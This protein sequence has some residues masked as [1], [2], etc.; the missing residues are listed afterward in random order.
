M[1][2]LRSVSR[3]FKVTV[4][5]F[6]PKISLETVHVLCCFTSQE[7]Y[8]KKA[9]SEMSDQ[10]YLDWSIVEGGGGGKHNG[11]KALQSEVNISD[12]IAKKNKQRNVE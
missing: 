2:K 5:F 12:F 1:P 11:N 7:K 10:M 3:I 9:E 6:Q 4:E 8:Q